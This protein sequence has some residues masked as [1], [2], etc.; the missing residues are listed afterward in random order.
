MTSAGLGAMTQFSHKGSKPGD[1]LTCRPQ[2][3][4]SIFIMGATGVVKSDS[5]EG[6]LSQWA[7]IADD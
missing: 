7:S 4:L 1:I 5:A 2:M 6:K 3:D